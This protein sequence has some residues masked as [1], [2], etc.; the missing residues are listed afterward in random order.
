MRVPVVLLLLALLTPSHAADVP[1]RYLVD[2]AAL[3]EV[4]TGSVLNPTS[5]TGPRPTS[6]A[7]GKQSEARY[8]G[9]VRRGSRA[10]PPGF[11]AQIASARC[12]LPVRAARFGEAG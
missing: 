1:V 8:A 9:A 3:K 2:D 10:L 11:R 4:G 7:V 5:R 12:A 6:T